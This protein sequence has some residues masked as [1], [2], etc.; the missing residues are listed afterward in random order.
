MMRILN[1]NTFLK[2]IK[3]IKTE[4]MYL[5]NDENVPDNDSTLISKVDNLC[6][7]FSTLIINKNQSIISLLLK[8][9]FF[10]MLQFSLK[11]TN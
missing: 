8:A 11:P 7:P 2:Q 6:R 9:V 4:N 3:S 1:V 10:G 5:N